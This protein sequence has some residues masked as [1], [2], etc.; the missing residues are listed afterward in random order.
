MGL[1]QRHAALSRHGS[2]RDA[3]PETRLDGGTVGGGDSVCRFVRWPEV[4]THA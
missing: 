1:S 3:F 4:G 2:A